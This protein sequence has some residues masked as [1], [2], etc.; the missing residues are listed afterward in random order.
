[1]SFYL[2]G[3]PWRLFSCFLSFAPTTWDLGGYPFPVIPV[4]WDV[5][6]QGYVLQVPNLRKHYNQ[7]PYI[8]LCWVVS[9]KFAFLTSC[10]FLLP[11]TFPG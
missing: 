4:T 3:F 2:Q 6:T 10:A 7:L 8:M 9:L 1:M 5:C 11:M